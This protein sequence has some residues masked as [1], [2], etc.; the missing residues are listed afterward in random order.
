MVEICAVQLD[1]SVVSRLGH[2]PIESAFHRVE[3]TDSQLPALI[4]SADFLPGG[5]ALNG[6]RWAG[7]QLLRAWARLAGPDSLTL[8]M[9]DPV[10]DSPAFQAFVREAG[11]VGPFKALPLSDPRPLAEVGSL[12]LSDTSIGR[13]AQWRRP[14]SPASFSLIGQIHTISTPAAIEQIQDLVSEPLEHWDAVLCSSTAGELLPA[15]ERSPVWVASMLLELRFPE[16]PLE[17]NAT[18]LFVV[19][20]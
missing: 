2:D 20:S 7:Q 18:T 16:L 17:P 13:W 11:H 9:G 3:M 12:F 8:L 19:A 5:G 14:A 6:R 10:Q 15:V 1:G 4:V